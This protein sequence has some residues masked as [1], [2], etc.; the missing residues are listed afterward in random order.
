MASTELG[1]PGESRFNPQESEMNY[2]TIVNSIL[3]SYPLGGQVGRAWNVDRVTRWISALPPNAPETAKSSG[4]NAA[5]AAT[6]E[7][8][9]GFVF[10][11]YG[12]TTAHR[13][14]HTR[15][16]P[17]LKPLL[18]PSLQPHVDVVCNRLGGLDGPLA[19]VVEASS[20][21]GSSAGS[22]HHAEPPKK[23]ASAAM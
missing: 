9:V 3:D 14:F 2:Q 6:V 17:H 12:A 16:L 7:A 23:R 20:L 10:H 11:Q 13:L 4:K 8:I 5:R 19:E 21:Q 1:A 18:E 15:I 22:V